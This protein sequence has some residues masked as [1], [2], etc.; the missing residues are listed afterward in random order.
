[1][2]RGLILAALA[3]AV[4][5][6]PGTARNETD[7]FAKGFI[8]GGGLDG[9]SL[10]DQDYFAGQGTLRTGSLGQ[11]AAWTS[12]PRSRCPTLYPMKPAFPSHVGRVPGGR[13]RRE[14]HG[15]TV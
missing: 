6:A 12:S 14:A 2:P 10:D 1:M 9:G 11:K 7:T 13:V 4:G 8:G 15:T 5:C 3:I